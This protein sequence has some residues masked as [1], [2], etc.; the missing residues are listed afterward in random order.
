MRRQC[1]HRAGVVLFFAMSTSLLIVISYPL[2]INGLLKKGNRKVAQL[3]SPHPAFHSTYVASHPPEREP[4]IRTWR[5]IP[6]S[7]LQGIYS[8]CAMRIS[9]IIMEREPWRCGAVSQC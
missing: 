4:L 2:A 6:Q 7:D 9:A 1:T 8:R 3:G 5:T